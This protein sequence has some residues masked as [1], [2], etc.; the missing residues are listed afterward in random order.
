MWIPFSTSDPLVPSHSAFSAIQDT[1]NADLGR[2]SQSTL[3]SHALAS[4]PTPASDSGTAINRSNSTAALAPAAFSDKTSTPAID[5]PAAVSRHHAPITSSR[6]VSKGKRTSTNDVAIE[7]PI[8][9]KHKRSGESASKARSASK[10]VGTNVAAVHDLS[11]DPLGMSMEADTI[12]ASHRAGQP[13][14]EVPPSSECTDYDCPPHVKPPKGRQST[15]SSATTVSKPKSRSTTTGARSG[16]KA[17]SEDEYGHETLDMQVARDRERQDEDDDDYG[18]NATKG[19]RKSSKKNSKVSSVT[20]AA[21]P[22]KP[23]GNEP[24]VRKLTRADR[25]MTL[26]KDVSVRSNCASDALAPVESVQLPSG[27]IVDHE[28]DN[29]SHGPRIEPVRLVPVVS[30]RKSKAVVLSSDDDNNDKQSSDVVVHDA[31]TSASLARDNP[32]KLSNSTLPELSHGRKRSRARAV[33]SSE[34]EDQ[35]DDAARD[36]GDDVGTRFA[37]VAS[38]RIQGAAV[39]ES[40]KLA[41]K[42]SIGRGRKSVDSRTQAVMRAASDPDGEDP[43][44]ADPN[45]NNMSDEDRVVEADDESDE[46]QRKGTDKV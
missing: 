23:N 32:H 29:E 2:K 34:D 13:L 19:K 45:V 9:K 21:A 8:S 46:D 22:S 41:G 3:A 27:S 40:V 30:K 10:V 17:M 25:T 37:V 44:V 38:R 36:T 39:P 24:K 33:V 7:L 5:Q 1:T 12:A 20:R 4:L 43:L 26:T 18:R 6:T 42:N 15:S 11:D 35:D 31:T 16:Q 28:I 14:E